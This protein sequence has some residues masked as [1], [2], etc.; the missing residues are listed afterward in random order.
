MRRASKVDN[1]QQEI[2]DAIRAEGWEVFIVKLPCDLFCWH[3][4]LDVWQPMECKS[5]RKKDGTTV[6]DKRQ[7][8]QI[9]FLHKTRCPVVTTPAEALDWLAKHYGNIQRKLEIA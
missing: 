6:Q 9:R 1:S 5:H 2:V 3:P 7:E 8:E 4:I